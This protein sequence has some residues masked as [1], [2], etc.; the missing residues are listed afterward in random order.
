ML[1]AA[2][3]TNQIS[4]VRKAMA[5]TLVGQDDLVDHLL[6]GLLAG[7]HVLIEG[8]P[9]L[10]KT[11]AVSSMARCLDLGFSR[12]QFTPDLMPSDLT[13][14]EIIQEDKAS[15]VR[16]LRFVQGPVFTN[17]LLADEI[18]RTPPRTQAALLEAMQER[19]VTAAG[20]RHVLPDP[21]F[22]LA[23]QNPIE[24]E[25]TYPLPESQ[26]DRF[27]LSIRVAYP[28]EAQE[29][30]IVVRTTSAVH[31][32][33]EPV[34]DG[35]DVAA[36]QELVRSVAVPEHVTV[37]A[38]AL[39]RATRPN[40]DRASDLVRRC[41]AWGAGPR[42]SQALILVAKAGALLQGRLHVHEDDVDQVLGSVLRHRLVLNF[43]AQSEHVTLDQVLDSVRSAVR[44][45][46]TSAT[47]PDGAVQ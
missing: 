23:T 8:V 40:D 22:V 38:V 27:L 7:G 36:L 19:Q 34:L 20:Q 28:S 1:D 5:S 31:S 47:V 29:Q 35:S 11:L 26:L 3:A 14:T 45:S 42:A 2:T 39:V 17:V 15:G 44:A 6:I 43:T 18:N 13:G 25:G 33:P 12:V 10:A 24:Q 46:T 21:F 41:V 9:G 37:R 32:L 30:E 4:A 16:S